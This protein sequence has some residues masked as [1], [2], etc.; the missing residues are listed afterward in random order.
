MD[1][2]N[3]DCTIKIDPF[4]KAMTPTINS[5]ALPNE[6]LINA[7]NLHYTSIRLTNTMADLIS[8]QI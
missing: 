3:D 2:I 7:P 1:P 4:C 5:T 6:Q 8:A